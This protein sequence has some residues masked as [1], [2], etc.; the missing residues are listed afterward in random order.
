MHG[1]LN[2]KLNKLRLFVNI[3]FSRNAVNVIVF[4]LVRKECHSLPRFSRKQSFN[5]VLWISLVM[6]I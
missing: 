3:S 1:Y 5:Q 2:V 6:V 4:S